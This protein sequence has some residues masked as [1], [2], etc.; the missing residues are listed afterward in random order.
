MT[1]YFAF[2]YCT[3]YIG[4]ANYYI[5]SITVHNLYNMNNY[6][7]IKLVESSSNVELYI[8]MATTLS[9]VALI[10]VVTGIIACVFWKRRT[11]SSSKEDHTY[12]LCRGCCQ[13]IVRMYKM[14]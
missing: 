10:A 2:I 9:V 6:I 13:N 7:P 8:G 11:Q 14:N 1:R 5:H 3:M 12:V 4:D